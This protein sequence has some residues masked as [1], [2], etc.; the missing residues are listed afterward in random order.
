MINKRGI[1][2]FGSFGSNE[3][4]SP[5]VV[6]INAVVVS[7]EKSM[8]SI[9]ESLSSIRAPQKLLQPGGE[10]DS[11]TSG[12]NAPSSNSAKEPSKPG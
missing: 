9:W 1:A 6:F 10:Q 8:A 2:D 11:I 4:L 3:F 12:Y 5:L 7:L